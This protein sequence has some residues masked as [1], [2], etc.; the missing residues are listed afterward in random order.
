MSGH[1]GNGGWFIKKGHEYILNVY[2]QHLL[3]EIGTSKQQSYYTFIRMIEKKKQKENWAQFCLFI[4][5]SSL[6][7]P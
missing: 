4:C 7:A 2:K 5:L 3:W 1:L 6:N